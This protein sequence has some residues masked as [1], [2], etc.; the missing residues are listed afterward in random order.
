VEGGFYVTTNEKQPEGVG[1]FD[2]FEEGGKTFYVCQKM[3]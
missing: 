1:F 2:Q 3:L